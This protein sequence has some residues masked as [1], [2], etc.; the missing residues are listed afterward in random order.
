MKRLH[1]D[2]IESLPALDGAL[3]W[4][5]VR[6]ALGIDGFGIN[7]CRGDHEG[8]LVVEEHA[9]EHQELYAVVAGRARFRSNEEE[10]EA[11]AGTLVLFEPGE[12]R[13]AHAVEGGTTV[14]A[15]GAEAERFEP[16]AWEYAF[17]AAGPIDLG[18]FGE[19][20]RA[21]AGGLERHPDVGFHFQR[22]RLAA[23]DGDRD[24]AL[25]QLR[26]AA[27][28]DPSAL[29]RARTDRFLGGLVNDASF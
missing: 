14:L 17:R 1:L 11:P 2:E 15:V 6:Y 5:P 24:G 19:A 8:D 20:R 7:S 9:D 16:S 25:E 4:K 21:I 23:A 3:Q 13:V 22:A 12:H 28:A 10:F 29:A 27:A 18:R 26:L